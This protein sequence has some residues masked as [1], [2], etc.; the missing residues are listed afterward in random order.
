MTLYKIVKKALKEKHYAK[1]RSD[2]RRLTGLSDASISKI[3]SKLHHTDTIVTTRQF[4]I[5]LVEIDE[6]S[7]KEIHNA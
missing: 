6:A 1:D 4:I 7:I 2:I 3:I 5:D